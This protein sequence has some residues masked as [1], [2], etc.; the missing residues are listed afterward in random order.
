MS[1]PKNTASIAGIRPSNAGA[2]S[3]CFLRCNSCLRSCLFANGSSVLG[4]GF[5]LAFGGRSHHDVLSEPMI[6]ALN[7]AW[8][9]AGGNVLAVLIELYNWYLR[10]TSGEAAILPTGLS[11]SI[12]VVC[13]LL[14]TGWKGWKLVYLHRV[15]V[16]DVARV[17][18]VPATKVRQK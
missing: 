16:T 5:V 1:N 15:G 2:V 14:F 18:V 4:I 11:L 13:I 12:I 17:D 9:H 7:D 3:D 10:Y 6:L 8:W